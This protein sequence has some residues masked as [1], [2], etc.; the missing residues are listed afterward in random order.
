MAGGAQEHMNEFAQTAPAVDLQQLAQRHGGMTA[1]WP[2]QSAD[3]HINLLTFEAGAGVGEHVNAELDVLLVGVAGAGE[4][5]IDGV[6]R[7]LRPGHAVLVLK[8]A[9]RA[10]RST[11]APFSYLSCHRRR[12]M[13]WPENAR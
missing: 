10:I 6:T 13:L 9:R 7:P 12:A 3:L 2:D 5:A 11:D 4:V 1:L 8:G